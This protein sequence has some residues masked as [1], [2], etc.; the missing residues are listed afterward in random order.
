M[1]PLSSKAHQERAAR[2][3]SVL[4]L[5]NH[6]VIRSPMAEGLMRDLFGTTIYCDSAGVT[7][8]EPDPFVTAVMAESGIDMSNHEP[9]ELDDLDDTWFDL[10]ISLSPQA[11]H[12]AL[13][14]VQVDSSDVIYWPAGD[15]TVV[16]GSRE[17]RLEAYREV[18]NSIR[19][20]LIERFG[21]PSENT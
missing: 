17:Q 8:G 19:K 13:S 5:C 15:P 1:D 18:M 7:A 20:Q 10:V 21:S 9:K 16:Q 6:N 14:M 4:F 12:V 11:H 2:P 3:S